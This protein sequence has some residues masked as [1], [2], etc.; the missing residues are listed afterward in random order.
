MVVLILHGFQHWD[1]LA[2]LQQF[3]SC[4]IRAAVVHGNDFVRDVP[5][6]QLKMQMLHRRANAS[7]FIVRGNDDTEQSQRRV[8]RQL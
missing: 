5:Q 2:K 3:L 7:F 8:V 4:G 1:V 6:A